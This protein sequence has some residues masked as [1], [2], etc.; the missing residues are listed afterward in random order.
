MVVESVSVSVLP[1]VPV[2]RASLAAMD[3]LNSIATASLETGPS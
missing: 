1:Y 2:R 3:C